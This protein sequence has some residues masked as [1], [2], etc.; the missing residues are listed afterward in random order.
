MGW[1]I[2]DLQGAA[3]PLTGDELLELTQAENSRKVRVA[4]LL[5]GFDGESLSSTLGS[6][7]PAK[8]ATIVYGATRNV[9]N[10]ANLR[11]QL[12]TGAG[13]VFVRGY[14][15]PGDGGGGVYSLD[16]ADTTSVDNQG[17]VI[18]AADGGRWKLAIDG[19]VS[20]QKFGAKCNGTDDD[21][22]F[23]Q[24][25]IDACS[26]VSF[27]P[28]KTVRILN[29]TTHTRRCI[30]DGQ[31]AT[32]KSAADG[33]IFTGRS[34]EVTSIGVTFYN[35]NFDAN[36]CAFVVLTSGRDTKIEKCTFFNTCENYVFAVEGCRDLVVK[37]TKFD[38]E[39][40]L[41]IN[42]ALS[43]VN[44]VG[45]RI[46]DCDFI[47]IPKGWGIRSAGSHDGKITNCRFDQE[48]SGTTQTSSAGQKVFTFTLVRDCFFTG[49]QINGKPIMTG[50]T[51]V[52]NGLT[53][54]VTFDVAF[55]SAN[56]VS[57]I[58][59]RG[60]EQIQV[61]L[62]SYDILIAG[63]TING[64]GDS[65]MTLLSDRLTV[66][67]NT[68]KYAAHAGIAFYGGYNKSFAAF[69]TFIDCSQLDNGGP[70][71]AEETAN[72]VFCGG[73]LIAGGN[74]QIGQ[75]T[76][77]NTGAMTMRYG[78]RINTV[79]NRSNGSEDA[80]INI[81][82]QSFSGTYDLGKI[83]MPCGDATK[84]IENVA[85]D[86][87]AIAYPAIPDFDAAF[88][89]APANTTYLTYG[90]FG[91]TI[92]TRDTTEKLFGLASARIAVGESLTIQ[93][94]G[95]GMFKD[96]I[97]QIDVWA[98]TSGSGYFGLT[99]TVGAPAMSWVEVTGTGWKQYTLRVAVSDGVTAVGPLTFGADAGN[100]WIEPPRISM[101]RIPK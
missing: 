24:K 35:I 37:S 23:Y 56:L 52:K 101:V 73:L 17:T 76:F 47:Q 1:K 45:F 59:Y 92:A 10:I 4:D 18:V 91:A 14:Y 50:Y 99:T 66:I 55:T 70:F 46:D 83:Y 78:V 85:I 43:L 29:K 81:A 48:P 33:N 58:G 34:F 79:E 72:S 96:C 5:P 88:T 63:C 2:S 57:F 12:K 100:L 27:P 60:A 98:K 20:I 31:G 93:P 54:T 39:S 22:P 19:A 61:N 75:N 11:L 7:D 6:D 68:V 30:I 84:R 64:T 38:G 67:Y 28:G 8:G 87:T 69:N 51:T 95:S 71:A 15:T 62:T 44:A 49:I 86:G 90:G 16:A 89:N 25:A 42:T 65:G 32:V 3:L 74:M 97:V 40:A 82:K 77:I 80:L 41:T 9:P 94:N 21:S 36:G 53:Y 26:V 13:A